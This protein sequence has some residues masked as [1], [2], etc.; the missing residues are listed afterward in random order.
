MVHTQGF[1]DEQGTTGLRDTVVSQMLASENGFD[2]IKTDWMQ[3]PYS[4]LI[5]E[6]S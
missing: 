1:F 3:D 2:E 6:V 4:R 5:R